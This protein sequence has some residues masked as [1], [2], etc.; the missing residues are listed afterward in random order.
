MLVCRKPSNPF[1][2]VFYFLLGN[3]IVESEVLEIWAGGVHS[4]HPLDGAVIAPCLWSAVGCYPGGL[5]LCDY[6]FLRPLVL[7]VP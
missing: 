3:V 6:V 5:S 1:S 7:F 4:A 2:R